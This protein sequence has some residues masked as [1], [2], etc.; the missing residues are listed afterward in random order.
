M[1]LTSKDLDIVNGALY[2]AKAN[3][4]SI[5]IKY[6]SKK[7][8]LPETDPVSIFMAG[9]PGAGKT[10]ASKALINRFLNTGS[11]FVRIDADELR[12]EFERYD[13]NNSFLFQRAVSILVERIH[14]KVLKHQQSFILDGTLS[15]LSIALKNIKRSLK[16]NRNVEIFYVYQDPIKAWQFVLARE[17]IERRKIL[18]S[19]F[20]FQYFSAR[21][22]VNDLKK[23]FKADIKVH[24]L[25]KNSDGSTQKLFMN[26]DKIDNQITEKY[27]E[28]SLLTELANFNRSSS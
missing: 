14:D 4:N 22:V 5:A 13:G 10:E 25:L 17:N 18:L 26:I 16:I 8:Y 6:T 24:L 12:S 9:S 27:N 7:D 19:D 23:Y 21:K 28:R 15:N 2:F 11:S 3:R 20:I 1:S